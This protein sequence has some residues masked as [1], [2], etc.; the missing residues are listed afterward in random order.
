MG[1]LL[2]NE[3]ILNLLYLLI[4]EER[5]EG[6]RR[7]GIEG[8]TDFNKFDRFGGELVLEE[9][10]KK[11]RRWVFVC[12]NKTFLNLL[13]LLILKKREEEKKKKKKNGMQSVISG[14]VFCRNKTF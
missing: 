5:G 13:Y 14:V 3:N 6:E 7:G 9:K 2:Q 11:K 4:L 12:E 10:K 8:G 1:C